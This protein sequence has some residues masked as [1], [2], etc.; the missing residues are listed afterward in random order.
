MAR[1]RRASAK[2]WWASCHPVFATTGVGL[3]FSAYVMAAQL[4]SL[5]STALLGPASTH[6][7]RVPYSEA[8]AATTSPS[9]CRTY[10][11]RSAAHAQSLIHGIG[12]TSRSNIE[13]VW[14]G[15]PGLS[16]VRLSGGD[17]SDASE[18]AFSDPISHTFGVPA[19]DG[20]CSTPTTRWWGKHAHAS[21]RCGTIINVVF[22][23]QGGRRGSIR[24]R[25]GKNTRMRARTRTRAGSARFA[26]GR[27]CNTRTQRVVF[28]VLRA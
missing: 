5:G 8:Q 26:T 2:I 13:R 7:I 14:D 16:A 9:Q 4:R 15:T 17:S 18:G 21:V 1:S 3:P 11:L 12:S 25:E 19:V 23:G 6:G 20:A 22:V 28:C 27:Q 10:Q 24:A